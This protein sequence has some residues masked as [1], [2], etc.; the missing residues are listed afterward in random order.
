MQLTYDHDRKA[1]LIKEG[2]EELDSVDFKFSDLDHKENVINMDEVDNYVYAEY[3]KKDVKELAYK[4]VNVNMGTDGGNPQRIGWMLPISM[5]T[6]E[7][8]E[9][10]AMEHVNQYVFFAYCYLLNREDVQNERINGRDFDEIL[11]EKFQDGCLLIIYKEKIPES[12]TLKKLELSL[13]RNGYFVTPSG[14]ANPLINEDGDLNLTPASEILDSNDKYMD[15]YMDIYLSQNV[16]NPNPF[17]RFFYLYQLVEVLLDREM[18][19]FLKNHIYLLENSRMSYRAA[20]TAFQKQ[21]E[22]ERFHRIVNK[23]GLRVADYADFDKL[24]YT[25][26]NLGEDEKK[27]PNPES[28]YQVRNHIVHRFRK[29]ASDETTV[30]TICDNLELY[31]YDLLICYKRPKVNRPDAL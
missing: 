4:K 5:L 10:L 9:T 3:Y 18:I 11:S 12:V 30:K 29:A 28:I 6:T 24:C 14:Y 8:E 27:Q 31:L 17:I 25:F 2:D 13:A 22:S 7:D 20:E 21:T 19:E 15:S 16:Y 26:L 23:S 1:F